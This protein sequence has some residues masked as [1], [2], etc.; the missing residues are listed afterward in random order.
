MAAQSCK[1]Y[2]TLILSKLK[3]TMVSKLLTGKYIYFKSN[4]II[5]GA[6]NKESNMLY[7]LLLLKLLTFAT[8]STL[9]LIFTN[10]IS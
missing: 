9:V 5:L 4:V 1:V 10:L 7:F 8:F 6:I 2:L 3:R